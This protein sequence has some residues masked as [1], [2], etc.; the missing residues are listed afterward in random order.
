[1][2]MP[3]VYLTQGHARLSLYVSHWRFCQVRFANLRR[4]S[5]EHSL[6]LTVT[7]GGISDRAR[8]IINEAVGFQNFKVC[9]TEKSRLALKKKKK[10]P[11]MKLKWSDF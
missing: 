8:E 5:I 10:F 11:K 4:F 6:V 2:L 9:Q 1:M 7:C 3:V